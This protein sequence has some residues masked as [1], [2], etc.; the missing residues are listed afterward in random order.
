[1][2]YNAAFKYEFHSPCVLMSISFIDLAK[3]NVFHKKQ[4]TSSLSTWTGSGVTL[5]TVAQV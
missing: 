4:N 3:E 2:K 1:M 5:V